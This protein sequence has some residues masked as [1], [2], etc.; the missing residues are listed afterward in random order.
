VDTVGSGQEGAGLGRQAIEALW[1]RV[2]T[3]DFVHKVAI[4][5]F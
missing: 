4:G 5:E 1:D 2:G 3:L